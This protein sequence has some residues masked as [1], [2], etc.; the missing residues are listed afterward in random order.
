M[1]VSFDII[2]HYILQTFDQHTTHQNRYTNQNKAKRYTVVT[3]NLAN[4]NIMVQPKSNCINSIKQRNS[5]SLMNQHH[6]QT[7]IGIA[8]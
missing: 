7:F 1:G 8:M 3:I 2:Y 4:N 6:E 5:R